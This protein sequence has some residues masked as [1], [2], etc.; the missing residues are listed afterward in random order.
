MLQWIVLLAMAPF[1]V[2]LAVR[3]SSRATPAPLTEADSGSTVTLHS[4][5]RLTVVLK[6]N[7]TAGYRWELAAVD[8]AILKPVAPSGKPDYEPGS[9]MLGAGGKFTFTFEAA[10]TGQTQLRL[11]YHRSFEQGVPPLQVFEMTA[12]VE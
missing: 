3:R 5:D 8:G 1:V 2:L 9:S 4:G 12:V 11:I 7:P 10:A 6:G